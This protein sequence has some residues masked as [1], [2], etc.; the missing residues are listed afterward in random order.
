[1][2]VIRW[3]SGRGLLVGTPR[4]AGLPALVAATDPAVRD[5][6]FVGPTGPGGAGGAPGTLDPWKPLRSVEDARRVWELSEQ[7][8]GAPVR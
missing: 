5:G 3:L 1:M 6:G 7:L 8:L 2:R 4:T